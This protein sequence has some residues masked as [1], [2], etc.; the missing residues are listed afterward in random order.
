MKQPNNI[1]N[2]RA[3]YLVNNF[4]SLSTD[5]Q[6]SPDDLQD[7]QRYD[8]LVYDKL[9]GKRLNFEG[10][11]LLRDVLRRVS[12]LDPDK[13]DMYITVSSRQHPS[14]TDLTANLRKIAFITGRGPR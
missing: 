4:D 14:N 2:G 13:F 8:M 12:W 11:R 3:V 1:P 7:G 10:G 5:R 6:I 9:N